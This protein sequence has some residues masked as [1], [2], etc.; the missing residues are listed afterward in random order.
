MSEGG[1]VVN[2]S[3]RWLPRQAA[4]CS[5]G[6]RKCRGC[7]LRGLMGSSLCLCE[8]DDAPNPLRFQEQKRTSLYIS[9]F[10]FFDSTLL[11]FI[12]FFHLRFAPSPF[13]G[14]ENETLLVTAAAGVKSSAVAIS[15]VVARTS[16]R[17]VF[18]VENQQG[19]GLGDEMTSS[20]F[21]GSALAAH[22]RVRAH[23]SNPFFNTEQD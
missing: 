19:V 16:L 6:V 18:H 20:A 17:C 1:L 22:C 21:P 10:L 7:T 12:F 4:L 9:F 23:T 13:V 15:A 8:N 14:G 11:D 2:T 5:V 3:G